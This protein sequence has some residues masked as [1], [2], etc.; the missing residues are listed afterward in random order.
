MHF[1][2]TINATE[3]FTVWVDRL[4]DLKARA[5]IY[6]RIKRAEQGNFGEY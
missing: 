4:A 3:E 1:M 2:N 6:M 5:A